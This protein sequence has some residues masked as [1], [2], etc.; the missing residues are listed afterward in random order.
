MSLE[1]WPGGA[2]YGYSEL[3][4]GN[5]YT[6]ENGFGTTPFGTNVP[7]I[8]PSLIPDLD[9]NMP[10]RAFVATG[11]EHW[12]F[13]IGRDRL[14]WGA[15]QTGNLMVSDSFKYHTMA[16]VTT[17]SDWF[18]YTFVTSFFPHPSQYI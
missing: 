12:S 16:R 11:G 2:F 3:S 10:Y 7:M 13:Q 4:V 14:S 5:T 15:G 6:L 9:F 17:F 1:T 18:K 8:P